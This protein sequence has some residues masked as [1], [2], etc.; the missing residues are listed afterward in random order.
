[1]V[2]AVAVVAGLALLTGCAAVQEAANTVDAADRALTTAQVCAQAIGAIDFSISTDP[3]TALDQTRS[4]AAELSTLAEQAADV[5]VSEA[6][7]SVATA[8]TSV[9]LDDLATP[10]DW[11]QERTSQASAVLN[12]CAGY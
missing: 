2:S 11:L 8:L 10:V 5:T 3:Q 1:M 6:L 7:S 4:A 12:A 9:T